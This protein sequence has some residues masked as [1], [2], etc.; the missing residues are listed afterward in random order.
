LSIWIKFDNLVY[1]KLN[2]CAE[3]HYRILSLI[4]SS[5]YVDSWA[6]WITAQSRAKK[7]LY[8]LAIEKPFGATWSKSSQ[9]LFCTLQ[10]YGTKQKFKSNNLNNSV[11]S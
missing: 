6:C 3:I 2:S 9:P 5:K 7:C 11:V 10:P 4:I 1:F 8:S